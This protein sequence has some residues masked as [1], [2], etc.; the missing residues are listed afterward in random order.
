MLTPVAAHDPHYAAELHTSPVLVLQLE[1]AEIADLERNL[2]PHG[3]LQKLSDPDLLPSL[4]GTTAS[5]HAM[6]TRRYPVAEPLVLLE[7][8]FREFL[9]LGEDAEEFLALL[10]GIVAAG[11]EPV[12]RE[13]Y[14][15]IREPAWR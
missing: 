1:F 6:L 15:D 3:Y 9:G 7:Q 2:R 14:R 5:H 4:A 12:P 11:H 13:F 8:L 10:D